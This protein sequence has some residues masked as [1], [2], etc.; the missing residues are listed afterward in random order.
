M[1]KALLSSAIAVSVAVTSFALVTAQSVTVTNGNGGS[2]IIGQ[3]AQANSQVGGSLIN[4]IQLM[5]NIVARLVPLGIGLAVVALFFGII[6]FLIQG[7]NDEKKRK[8]WLAWMGYSIIGLFVMVAIW[9]LVGFISSVL[10]IGVGGTAP[11][12]GIPYAQ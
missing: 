5:Q 2:I 12:P 1:K 4:L 10:G 3:Q 7:R 8:D 9:G 11:T 6:M